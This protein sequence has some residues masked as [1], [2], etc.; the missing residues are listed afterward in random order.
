M[1]KES[2]NIF[3]VLIKTLLKA[4]SSPSAPRAPVRGLGGHGPARAEPEGVVGDAVAESA[5]DELREINR[6]KRKKIGRAFKE[7]PAAAS[8][9]PTPSSSPRAAARSS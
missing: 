9:R 5:M 6:G 3:R 1:M 2:T 8:A 7:M 4:A